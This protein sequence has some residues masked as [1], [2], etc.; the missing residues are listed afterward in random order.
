M[1]VGCWIAHQQPTAGAVHCT[2]LYARMYVQ[3]SEEV[4][5]GGE[6]EGRLSW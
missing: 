6:Q 2:Y 1:R 4:G 5:G 3:A